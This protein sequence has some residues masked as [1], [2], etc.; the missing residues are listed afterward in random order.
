MLLVYTHNLTPRVKYVFRQI[1]INILNIDVSFTTEKSFFLNSNLPK[2]SYTHSQLKNELFFQSHPILFE[3][4]VIERNISISKYNSVISFFLV[5]NSTLPFDPFG[6]SFYMLS[7]YEEYLPHIKDKFGRFE[8]KESL[9]FKYGFLDKPVVDQWAQIIKL[10]ISTKYSSLNF[11]SKNFN[12]I[13][14]IDVDCAYL[15]LEKGLVRTLGSSLIDFVSFNY[16]KFLRRFRVLFGLEKDPYDSFKYILSLSKKYKL[17]TI[18]FFLLGDYGQY[19]K[20][21]SFSNK[22]FQSLI[23]LVNDYCS[24]GIHPSFK[25]LSHNYILLKELERLQ[26]IVHQEII[27]SRQHY[28]K[29]DIPNMFKNLLKT[30]IKNDY[31]MGFASM[32]G[33]RSG[34]SNS[35]FFYDLDLEIE[36]DLKI[37]PFM[38]MDVTLKNYLGLDSRNATLYIKKIINEVK[39]VNGTFI[40]IWH[41]QSLSFE[42]DWLEWDSVYKNMIKY[43]TDLINE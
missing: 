37:H 40:S 3:K 10:E 6:T 41:N 12:F 43:A 8:A 23:K 42:D 21:I 4:E 18:F 14:T 32:P 9:A 26:Q 11:P 22:K 38:V 15:Y 1:F 35:Y 2:I 24:V 39:N 34:T 29:L 7:R 28:I 20:S 16:S 17:N 27:S 36:T 5:K 13:N 30:S 25:S 31:S 19:D 33:F